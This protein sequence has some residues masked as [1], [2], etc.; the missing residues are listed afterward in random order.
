MPRRQS[1]YHQRYLEHGAELVDRIGYDAPYRFTTTESEHK[2]TRTAA[3]MY[4]VYHQGAVEIR[5]K[6]AQALLQRTAVND[7]DRIGDGQVLYSSLCNE[8]GG[9]VDDLTIYR[10]SGDQFWLSP[11]PSRVDAVVA[12]LSG[13]AQGMNAYV[14]N[15]VPGTGF[16]S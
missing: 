12:W 3:G 13:H 2:A 1:P 4:D 8:Q 15:L 6:E 14:T 16:I 5:G 9:I 10:L 11:T 7:L